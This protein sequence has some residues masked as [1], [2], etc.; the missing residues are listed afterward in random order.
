M[1]RILNEER[2]GILLEAA[3]YA[4]NKTKKQIPKLEEQ[5]KKEE[6]YKKQR[7]KSV[8]EEILLQMALYYNNSDPNSREALEALEKTVK[9]LEAFQSEIEKPYEK[10]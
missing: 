8:A 10:V 1:P 7:I 9:I 3:L 6:D 2:A 4:H 5:R